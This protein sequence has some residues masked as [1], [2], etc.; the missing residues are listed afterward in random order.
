MGLFNDRFRRAF[1]ESGMSY[2]EIGRR[3]SPTK[4]RQAVAGWAKNTEPEPET[5][6]QLA[7]ILNKDEGWLAPH[8]LRQT[9][10]VEGLPVRGQ[11]AAGVWHEISENQDPD[12]RRAPVAPDPRYPVGHQYVLEV[13]GN[14][15][16]KFAKD[17]SLITCVDCSVTDPRPNDLVV[18]ERSRGGLIETTVKRL[19][20]VN[21][22]RELWPESD[23]PAHQEKL[24][25]A[26]PK[27]EATVSIKAIVIWASNPIPRGD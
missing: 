9:V 7:V 22:S 16:N 13:V 12:V 14:S 11:V 25:L 15:V 1:K 17:G 4:T 24:A 5:V 8:L 18:V 23:D 21:G 27:G 2:A 10:T 26:H 6:R 19:K 3:V 20:T